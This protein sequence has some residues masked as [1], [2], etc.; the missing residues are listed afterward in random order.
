M[1]RGEGAVHVSIFA[2]SVMWGNQV[3]RYKGGGLALL[4]GAVLELAGHSTVGGNRAFA[5]GG[6]LYVESAMVAAVNATFQDN[7]VEYDG[8]HVYATKQS[9]LQL[10]RCV[11]QGG[12][13]GSSGG[14]LS[15]Y[16]FSTAEV[17][18]SVFI[19]NTAT[20]SGAAASLFDESRLEMSSS[21]MAWNAV[22][23]GPGGGLYLSNS[24]AGVTGIVF[25]GNLAATGGAAVA[26][27]AA[28]VLGMTGCNVTS[29]QAL[30]GGGGGLLIGQTS[31]ATVAS[32]RCEGNAAAGESGYG[33]AVA[34]VKGAAR[35]ALSEMALEG[36]VAQH[37]TVYIA[38]PGKLAEPAV[39]ERLHFARNNNHS[40][41][42]HNVYFTYEPGGPIP[43][44]VNCSC[45]EGT[46]LEATSPTGFALVQGSRT[47]SELAWPD[48]NVTVNYT[49]VITGE[50]WA[51]LQPTIWCAPPLM[52]AGAQ[53][54]TRAD[55]ERI[56][57][58][59]EARATVAEAGYQARD[60]YGN[61][62]EPPSSTMV[63][64]DLATESA[65][66]DSQPDSNSDSDSDSDLA[67][68]YPALTGETTSAYS[69]QGAAF[70]SLVLVGQP[71]QQFRVLFASNAVG[72]MSVALYVALQP[73][74]EGDTFNDVSKI[75]DTCKA[76]TLK[77]TSDAAACTSCDDHEVLCPGG[78]NFTLED[79]YWI[80]NGAIA[81]A[82]GTDDPQ[83]LL[84]RVV[85]CDI[86]E[87]CTAPNA[88]GARSNTN[89]SMEVSP[90]V[91]C[92][93]GYD[94]E[95]VLCGACQMGY[96]MLPTRICQRCPDK[97]ATWVRLLV[98]M[99]S[100]PLL[101]RALLHFLT[102][103]NSEK[104]HMS[105]M[106]T[107]K[108]QRTKGLFD[109][110]LGHVQVMSQHMVVFDVMRMPPLFQ[111]FM[112]F[113]GL[114]SLDLL[115][116][117]E[118]K[119]RISVPPSVEMQD[120]A[121]PPTGESA[122]R[123]KIN[124]N[125][126]YQMMQSSSIKASELYEMKA[127]RQHTSQVNTMSFDDLTGAEGKPANDEATGKRGNGKVEAIELIT[128]PNRK[129]EKGPTMITLPSGEPAD[130]KASEFRDPNGS[131]PAGKDSDGWRAQ[132]G[133]E[134]GAEVR[135]RLCPRSCDW[136]MDKLRDDRIVDGKEGK[137][138]EAQPEQRASL[139]QAANRAS[140]LQQESND[141]IGH[142][143]V[144]LASFLLVFLHP[145]VSTCMLQ[146]F[147]CDH[148]HFDSSGREYFLRLDR[149]HECFTSEWWL[150]A[151][152]SLLVIVVYTFGLPCGFCA[153]CFHLY[154]RKK[155]ITLDGHV[156]YVLSA[157]LHVV[158]D[159]HSSRGVLLSSSD[160]VAE[161]FE[162]ETP[163][164]ERVEVFPVFIQE[165]K[166]RNPISNIES[167]LLDPKVQGVLG[168]FITPFKD[169]HFYWTF[170]EISRRIMTTSM[171]I[172]VQML[173]TDEGT[174]LLYALLVATL[175][176][177]V[178]CYVRP[179]KSSTVNWFQMLILLS[180]SI[181]VTG[182]IADEYL[183]AADD[184][185]CAASGIIL[186]IIQAILACL[187]AGYIT[188]DLYPLFREYVQKAYDA[189][190]EQGTDSLRRKLQQ[191][192]T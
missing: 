96:E 81:V 50:S 69:G 183:L 182:Y 3:A 156:E 116:C 170:Y 157:K 73:C 188:M 66:S 189:A 25:H 39:L 142:P 128:M 42:G 171:V 147:N 162:K 54:L 141:T 174:D 85:R 175:A 10:A 103:I 102:S 78:N 97:W 185:A 139:I 41:A 143:H 138:K 31:E 124:I 122:E 63:F 151:M 93:E 132:E 34:V 6:G 67:E 146:V 12:F 57:V 55:A 32:T 186:I 4:A 27:T 109:V 62:C 30:E 2:G 144:A 53:S 82:C 59:V 83:C 154:K 121:S 117:N 5:H 115:Y 44:C 52:R 179:Y 184:A 120:M 84:D 60:Y 126:A 123:L 107:R 113:P 176:L 45:P 80:A 22:S 1:G 17:T 8:G 40:A 192:D 164:G 149:S 11:L 137:A 160:R 106:N 129:L 64:A 74:Q 91:L 23:D 26:L 16:T 155:V 92:A 56:R 46:K 70:D 65:N 150:Y 9:R 191:G 177:L 61:L 167:K 112:R 101:L 119:P 105:L 28:A 134:A 37:G 158:K 72:W 75:C 35:V 14:A 131:A 68:V 71:G 136:N 173:E 180:Q 152:V 79:G 77:F 43:V 135:P 145:T 89:G 110:A 172:F 130:L 19:S 87:A 187:I 33:G 114:L 108:L 18:A 24:S 190:K 13:A 95:V 47:V 58:V 153:L 168:P 111:A 159:R 51:S 161:S 118:S 90:E 181:M 20:S 140:L 100:I 178:H 7:F 99:C 86:D 38:A 98:S 21:E 48:A 29:N 165:A 125:P 148:L 15:I 163:D 133:C 169:K 166:H 88:G 76:G 104:M 94:S 36:N 49:G 127:R